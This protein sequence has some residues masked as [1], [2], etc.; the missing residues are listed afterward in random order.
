MTHFVDLKISDPA[1]EAACRA[2]GIPD[3]VPASLK[4]VS[5]LGKAW[6][7][8][9][10]VGE[11]RIAFWIYGNGPL[12]LLMHGWCGRGSHLMRFV[13]P[14]VSAGFSVALFDAP[15]HGHS[16]GTISSVIHA[17]KA[18]LKLANHLGSVHGII[19]HST[20]S[21]AALWAMANGLSVRRSVHLGGPTSLT[22]FVLDTAHAHS[23]NERQARKFC[24]WAEEFMEINMDSVDLP[25]LSMGLKHIGLIIHDS[26][27]REVSPAQ[28]KALH[29]VWTRSVFIE[30]K[31]LGHRRLLSDQEVID[32]VTKF[33]ASSLYVRARRK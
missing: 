6:Q 15:G 14:L 31:G 25:A 30:T 22:A 16:S 11:D 23:L 5:F 32:S 21:T 28:S 24:A 2:F 3:R 18:A 26:D 29:V 27:D 8:S 7:A 20:G 9:L 1:L 17:G 33:V 4:E 13:K 19:A 10:D 12:I